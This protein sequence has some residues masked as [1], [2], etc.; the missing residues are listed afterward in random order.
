MGNV[1]AWPK[2][3]IPKN[4]VV[5]VEQPA[6]VDVCDFRG[7][8]RIGSFSYTN[9]GCI[10][11]SASIGRYTSIGHRVLIGPLEHPVDRLSTHGFVFGD[12]GTFGL[13]DAY[14]SLIVEDDFGFNNQRT[15]IGNDVW[16]GANSFI[17]RGVKVGDGAIIAAGAVVLEDVPDYAI[18][19]G[20]PAKVIKYRFEEKTIDK[21]KSLKW[22]DYL[23]VSS[24]LN[25]ID[26]KNVNSSIDI[27]TEAVAS[28]RIQKLVSEVAL[29]KSGVEIPLDA[30]NQGRY[31]EL[32]K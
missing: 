15:V 25:G 10:I 18:C 32:F 17:R 8:N 11:Y 26:Y 21:L 23:L 14:N 30:V 13:S 31:K 4:G 27:I 6:I 7:T 28:K 24:R 3:Q 5:L 1:V 16:I 22:W 9:V 19:G 29:F 2:R 12:S 20:V